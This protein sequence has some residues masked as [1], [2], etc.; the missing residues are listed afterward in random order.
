[1]KTQTIVHSTQVEASRPG[2][3]N[4]YEQLEF[5]RFN[6]VKSGAAPTLHQEFVADG[7]R[8]FRLVH[9]FFNV[10]DHSLQVYINGQLMREGAD[11]DY[12]EIDSQ[13]IRLNYDILPTDIV[14]LRV[15]GGTSGPLLYE[16]YIAVAGQTSVTLAGSYE[17]G[18]HSLIVYVSGAFQTLGIDY[19][20]TDNKTVTFLDPLEAG[21]IIVLRVE[22]LP[23]VA[24][25]YINSIVTEQRDIEGRIVRRETTGDQHL[26]EEYEYDA[27]GLPSR[28]VIRDSGYVIT[29]EYIWIGDQVEIKTTVKEGA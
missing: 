3:A 11:N 1:M 16:R 8:E 13:T 7:N 10:G 12:V 2:Y 22:G 23:T 17:T 5:G 19:E 15:N 20:E 24:Q 14:T 28:M 21:D 27:N 26:I 9:G 6:S 18:N 4:L 25:K 29:K